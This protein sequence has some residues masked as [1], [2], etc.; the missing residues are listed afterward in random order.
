MYTC[1]Y[2]LYTS[3]RQRTHLAEMLNI[4]VWYWV[5]PQL[6]EISSEQLLS[7]LQN[8]GYKIVHSVLIYTTL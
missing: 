6:I 3:R 8:L 5:S 4:H 7:I 1:V 2:T